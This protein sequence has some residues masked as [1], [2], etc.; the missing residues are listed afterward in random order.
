MKMTKKDKEQE[1]AAAIMGVCLCLLQKNSCC[2]LLLILQP[3]PQLLSYVTY[4]INV[5]CFTYHL[6]EF[7]VLILHT[8]VSCRSVL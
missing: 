4:R 7:F 1:V 5:P 2:S 6:L 8:P 3:L